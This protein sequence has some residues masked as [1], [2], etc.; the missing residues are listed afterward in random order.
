[1]AADHLGVVLAVAGGIH[2]EFEI[3]KAVVLGEKGHEGSEG[4]W[5]RGG[6]VEYLC[7]VWFAALWAG[8]VLWN[9]DGQGRRLGMVIVGHSHV[10][11][12]AVK[13]DGGAGGGARGGRRRLYGQGVCGG[14]PGDHDA[15]PELLVDTAGVVPALLVEAVAGTE[16]NLLG[17]L[18][19][20]RA[21]GSAR[22]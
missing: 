11:M 8:N 22:T 10:G 16:V 13:V 5:G 19:G 9:E 17:Q 18:D 4:V 12:V 3:L 1:M 6:V 2:C 21:L 15:L 14:L 7:E 20:G